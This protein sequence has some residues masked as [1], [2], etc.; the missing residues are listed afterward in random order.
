MCTSFNK[1]YKQLLTQF[2]TIKR[3]YFVDGYSSCRKMVCRVIDTLYQ[4][5]GTMIVLNVQLLTPLTEVVVIEI[6]VRKWYSH[7]YQNVWKRIEVHKH[8]GIR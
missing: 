7:W 2:S 4:Y 3:V 1:E 6:G 5:L 8:N